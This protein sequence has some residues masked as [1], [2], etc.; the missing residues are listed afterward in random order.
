M[1]D[2]NVIYNLLDK[3]IVVSYT[4]TPE[5]NQ[6]RDRQKEQTIQWL[7]R[8]LKRGPVKGGTNHQL[9]EYTW[10]FGSYIWQAERKAV[11]LRD[12]ICRICNQ[13]KSAEVHHI[14][15][16]FLKGSDHPRNLIGLCLECHDEVHRRIDNGISQL[17]TESLE[18]KP[19][20]TA[21]ITGECYLSRWQ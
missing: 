18:I 6:Q 4:K 1:T 17:L 5:V 21:S 2:W 15:P 16:R 11:L 9:P 7:I 14:R 19:R 20:N 13:R 10:M 3:N 8:E 12:P